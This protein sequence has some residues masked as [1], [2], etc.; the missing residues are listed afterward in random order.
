MEIAQIL[1]RE[2]PISDLHI[3]DCMRDVVGLSRYKR[4]L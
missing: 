1:D 2:V 3:L 4:N